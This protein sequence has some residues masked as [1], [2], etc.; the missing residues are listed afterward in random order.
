MPSLA[1]R[2]ITKRFGA[3]WAV[4]QVD[5]AAADGELLVLLGPS[6]SGK[7]T[8][9]MLIAGLHAPTSGRVFLGDRDVTRL[10]PHA[11]NVAMMFQDAALYPH[12]TVRANLAFGLEARGASRRDAAQRAADTAAALDLAAVLDRRPGELS[13]GERRRAA[14]GRALAAAP[15]L[16][17]LDEPLSHI[18]P[19]L[20]LRIREE[21]L[22]A[23][24][25]LG[26]TTVYVTHDHAEAMALGDRIAVIHD[27][28]VLQIATPASLY[29]APCHALVARAVGSP[30]MNL[31]AAAA[32]LVSGCLE[33]RAARQKFALSAP[34]CAGTG[35]AE[36]LV[37]LRPEALR[38]APAPGRI[39]GR[40]L[41]VQRLGRETLATVDAGLPEPL[42]VLAAADAALAAGA[43]LALDFKD[44]DAHLFDA[45]DGRRIARP[46]S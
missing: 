27:G 25:A 39:R 12:M 38:P 41:R 7:S 34:P 22:A 36:V 13:G 18:D 15:G 9:L 11:R 44:A 31:F 29:A 1:L 32:T 8:L 28:R 6:G 30:P 35:T 4:R 16:L 26:V 2:G 40:I 33:L 45:A 43:P 14:L 37:G 5:C 17:L 23:R 3:I 46:A 24:R 19:A 42:R 20:Q 21:I 10:P